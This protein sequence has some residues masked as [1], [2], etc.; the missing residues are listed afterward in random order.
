MN[1]ADLKGL[2]VR[3]CRIIMPTFVTIRHEDRFTHGIPDITVTGNKKTLWSEVKLAKPD[4]KS[5]GI[6]D[7]TMLR[8]RDK[9]YAIYV[10]YQEATDG[11]KY[12]FI[13]DP[14]E[15]GTSINMWTN[16]V[17]GFNHSWVAN[18]FKKILE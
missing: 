2:L 17:F 14:K 7:L 6:Q 12:T 11:N 13:V 10:V 18:E 1:E 15:I 4:F 3:E 5:K 16:F 9:G 8:L